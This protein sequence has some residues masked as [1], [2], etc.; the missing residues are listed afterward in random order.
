MA[1]NK[2]SGKQVHSGPVIKKKPEK[3]L[4]Q[5]AGIKQKIVSIP[6]WAVPAILLVTFL[7]FIPA[8]NA[9]FVNLDDND[10]V[11][12]NALL[13]NISDLKLLLTTPVQGNYHPLTMLSL[14]FN[15]MISGE[16]AWSYH[17]FNLLFH[18]INCFLVFRLVLL[19]SNRNIVIAF[20]TA[21]LFGIHPMH[22]ESV[23][24][25]SERKDVLY[26]LFFL[27]GLISYTK[28][29][30]TSSGKHYVLTIVFLI[31]SLLS[32]PAAVIFPLALFCIDLLRNRRINSKLFIEKIPFFILA[33]ALGILTMLGQ[34]EAGA[35]GLAPFTMGTKILF[36]FY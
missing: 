28:Y 30:D 23:A 26:A 15:Y 8:L 4:Q 17:L 9:G 11:T 2:R 34:K 19:L 12:N 24:W 6:R 5:A 33:L 21:V 10:Y 14:F 16:N 13:K 27:A 29:I 7:A 36:G 22:V 25:V 3:H 18:L 20:T 32:K 35:T 1:K 31:L